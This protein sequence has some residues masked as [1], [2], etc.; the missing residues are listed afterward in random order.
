[1]EM[2]ET[3][4]IAFLFLRYDELLGLMTGKHKLVE[5]PDDAQ[6]ID[7]DKDLL[8]R[9]FMILVRSAEFEPIPLSCVPPM[10]HNRRV[11]RPS[12]V[13]DEPSAPR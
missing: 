13:A 8:R 9:G 3:D 12:E 1:M 2:P 4:R 7:M 6:I 5:L 11:T 10:L